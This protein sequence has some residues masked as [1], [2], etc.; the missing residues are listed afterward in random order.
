MRG[1]TTLSPVKEGRGSGKSAPRPRAALAHPRILSVA[2]LPRKS[3]RSRTFQKHEPLRSC[4]FSGTQVIYFPISAGN[5]ATLVIFS[6]AAHTR[7]PGLSYLPKAASGLTASGQSP[8]L[9]ESLLLNDVP[10]G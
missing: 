9:V 3:P 6:V 1:I 10:F 7:R 2:P 4:P 5:H 8:A